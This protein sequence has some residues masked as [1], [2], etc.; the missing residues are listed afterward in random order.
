METLEIILLAA[1]IPTA[2]GGGFVGLLFWKL[3]R[4]I[5]QNEEAQQKRDAARMDFELY[6]VKMTSALAALGKANA[7]AI[8]NGHSNGE[9]TA[10]LAWLEEVKHDQRS[11]LVAHGI[12]HIYE[13]L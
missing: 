11:F 8:K 10:A 3:K 6:Q 9:T 12:E 1:G 5:A 13:K 7:L 2:I 4:Q